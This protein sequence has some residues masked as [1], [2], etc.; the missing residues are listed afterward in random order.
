LLELVRLFSRLASQPGQNGLSRYN[1]VFVLSGG[2]KLNY[3]GS[4]KI[5]ED[6]IDGVDGGL[7]QDAAYVMCLDSLGKGEE[8]NVHVSKPPKEGSKSFTFVE[9]LICF[10]Q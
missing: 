8:L 4:K 6:Q 5:L 7:F 3:L 2:G 10:T 9:V 1:L